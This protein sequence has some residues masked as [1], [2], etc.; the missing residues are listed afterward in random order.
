MPSYA[1]NRLSLTY[2]CVCVCFVLV[3]VVALAQYVQDMRM[4]H[5][6]RSRLNRENVVLTREINELRRKAKALALQQDAVEKVR[7]GDDLKAC[8]STDV[9]LLY[10]RDGT[11]RLRQTLARSML[12]RLLSNAYI[13]CKN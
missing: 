12:L 4:F 7:F 6:D 8:S 1:V 13:R 3:I 5:Q 10:V 2:I 11:D 9:L